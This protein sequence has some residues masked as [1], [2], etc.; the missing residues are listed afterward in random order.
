MTMQRLEQ[1]KLDVSHK[2]RANLFNWR[3]QFTP[4][5]IEHLL[6]CYAPPGAI[7]ADPFA[8]SGTVL[9]ECARRG[10]DAHGFEINPA[11][12]TM[13]K[14]YGLCALPRPARL[15]LLDCFER[16]LFLYVQPVS[17][18]PLFGDGATFREQHHN[19]IALVRDLF[20]TLERGWDKI[21]ALNLLFRCEGQKSG[22]LGETVLAAWRSLK[23]AALNLPHTPAAITARLCDAR[24][25]HTQTPVPTNLL[26]TSPPYINVFNY[27]QNHRALLEAVGWD[28]LN[29][30]SSEF[31]SNRKNRGNRFKTV[32]QYALDMEQALHNFWHM[33]QDE[34]RMILVIGRESNVRSS[35]FY[36]GLLVENLL[37]GIGGFTQEA[38]R[39]R[40][41]LNKF[42]T[43]IIEDILIYRKTDAP[44]TNP[45]GRM[46]ALRHLENAL[47]GAHDE[48]HKD[49]LAAIAE[50]DTVT[51]S[52]LFSPKDA[53]AC[54]E[55][56]S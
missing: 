33:L 9:L 34:G 43:V 45:I 29:V 21:L 52:P 19:L 17:A 20:P 48:A 8:G 39:E 5:L 30:A 23:L 56:A 24:L 18:L 38:K 14:F 10:L 35:P 49:I 51:S 2:T 6:D 25:A 36:N 1:A 22:D 47:A 46:V 4:E 26:L 12:Y 50:C 42:G 32:I 27:H 44:N 15:E 53:Y 31:G 37:E 16:Q 13:S 3:G 54:A 55:N 40:Q 41:F 7:V 11:A 28:M